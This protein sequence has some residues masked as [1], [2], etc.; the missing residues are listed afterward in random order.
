MQAVIQSSALPPASAVE[1][2]VAPALAAAVTV[3]LCAP[4]ALTPADVA[5]WAAMADTVGEA[6]VFAQPWMLRPALAALGGQPCHLALVSDSDGSLIGVMPLSAKRLPGR[7]PL[8]SVGDWNHPNSFLSAVAVRAGCEAAF[9][10]A[11]LPMMPR[12]V[13]KA[14]CITIDALVEGGPVHAGLVAAAARLGAP[15]SVEQRVTRAMLATQEE[16]QSYWDA[17]VRP[18]KRKELRR[19]WNR[20]GEL[21]VVTMTAMGREDKVAGWIDEFLM[22]E[23]SGWKGAAG[24]ALASSPATEQFFRRSMADAQARGAL[25]ITALRLDGRAIAMLITLIDGQAGFSFKTAFDEALARFSPG[26]LLQRE[27]LNILCAHRLSWIDSCAA[28]DHPMIDSLWRE[29]RSVV[30]LSLPLPGIANRIA[31]TVVR[32][33]QRLWH[34]MKL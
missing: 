22:L 21:G 16:P 34:S 15:V 32:T 3:R 10:Y 9:W 11:L 4:V 13:P 27:S 8:A 7:L 2:G 31:Y 24:S 25:A 14:R 20:L 19:Q 23:A 6:N 29:R 1:R 17:N 33:A 26:V 28:Q 30:T 18:K 5:A 12:L